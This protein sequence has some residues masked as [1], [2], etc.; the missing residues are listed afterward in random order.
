MTDY[1]RV[2]E[3]LDRGNK[4][5]KISLLEKL[6]LETD[7]KI[8]NKIISK[9]DD[10]D[11]Q[12]RGEAFSCLVLNEN[13]IADRLIK[14]LNSESKYIRGFSALILANRKDTKAISKIIE[15]TE[16]SS[17]MVRGCA[18]G[19]LGFLHA[20][21]ASSVI[22]SCVSD[23]NLEVKKSALKAAIDIGVKL[24][25]EEIKEI[26]KDKDEELEKLIVLAKQ[27]C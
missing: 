19:A 16:D 8:I 5:E 22:H 21:E 27:K 13:S 12:V 2:F 7:E 4:D 24:P 18:L 14:N 20:D 10:E 9:L 26:S 25:P 23:E 3:I 6:T 1:S 17:S 11:I 15:L